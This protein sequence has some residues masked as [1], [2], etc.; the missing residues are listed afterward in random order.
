[1][2]FLIF[3]DGTG[4][5]IAA[6]ALELVTKARTLGDVAVFYVGPESEE[7]VARFGEHGATKVHHLETS[8]ALPSAQAAA[9]LATVVSAEPAEAVLFGMGYLDRD[10][11]GRLS[12]LIGSP[13][14]SNAVDIS[15]DGGMVVVVNE[16][17]GGTVRV[18]TKATGS[19]AVVLARPKAFPAEPGNQAT[20][21]VASVPAP[22][23]GHAG[24]VEVVERH[25]EPSA[26]P[27]LEDADLIVSG[28]RGLG[29]ASK[30]AM[31]EELAGLLKGAV[32]ATR[33]VVDAG[34]VPYSTQ[35]GQTG[36]TVKPAVYIAC[37]ISGAM[38]HV[39][40]MKDAT[41]II[42]INKDPE[43]P[44]FAISDLGIVGDVHK[45]VPALIEALRARG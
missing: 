40:G 23:V 19:P 31:L 32:G 11:A 35:V 18:L 27:D 24:A 5:T 12:A 15:L 26:G 20:P 10:V 3:A 21:E 41:T 1:M 17:L 8:L 36:K 2:G 14:L 22:E 4:D 43:A 7:A 34:W 30:F 25:V 38:Q 42:A 28:G 29:D 9:A 33:A 44:I 6:S 45:V 39:V 16:I 37:G 13:V